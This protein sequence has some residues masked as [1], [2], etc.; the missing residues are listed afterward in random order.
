LRCRSVSRQRFQQAAQI[1]AEQLV[2]PVQHVEER[3]Q[4]EHLA[5]L[6]PPNWSEQLPDWSDWTA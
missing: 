2:E 5:R 6:E 3:R 4:S 1:S